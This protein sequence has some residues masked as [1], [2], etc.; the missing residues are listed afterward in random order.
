MTSTDRPDFLGDSLRIHMLG[1]AGA[2]M[3]GL[4]A[5]LMALRHH[6]SGSDKVDTAEVRRLAQL[7]LKF[8]TPHHAEQV[9]GVD[10]VIQS[11]AIKPGNTA[12]D[13]AIRL[14]IPI[15]QRADVLAAIMEHKKGILVCGMHG[16]TTTSAMAAHVLRGGGFKPS[17]YVGAEIPLLKTNAHWEPQSEYFVAEGDESDGTI[18]HYFPTHTLVLNIE[19]E[20]LDYYKNLAAI[21]DVFSRL[22]AQTSEKVF[23]CADDPGAKHVCSIHPRAISY[24][25]HG[26]CDYRLEFL[27]TS[28]IQTHLAIYHRNQPLGKTLLNV[29]GKHNAMN[30]LA[31]TAL[32]TELGIPFDKITA[33]LKSFR[34]AKRRFEIKYRDES[35]MVVDDYGHHPTE[36]QATL[37]TARSLGAQRLVVMFQPH[38]YSRTQALGDKFGI[39]FQAADAVFVTDI[40]A[41]SEIP[42]PG[43][44]GQ[45][46]VDALRNAGHPHAVFHPSVDTIHQAAGRE[47]TNTNLFISLGAGNIHEAGTRLAN[48]LE[49]RKR[50]LSVMGSGSIRLYEPMREHTTLRVGGPAQFWAEPETEEGFATLVRFCSTHNIPL[51]VMGRGSNLLVRDGGI[52]G[53]VAHLVRGEFLHHKIDGFEITAGVGIRLKQLSGIARRA[54]IGGFEWMEGIPGNLG[55]SLRMNAGA[56]GTQTFD[57]VTRIKFCN[58]N[59]KIFSKPPAEFDIRY[60]SVP[61]LVHHYALAATL[62]GYPSST[63]EIDRKLA[64]SE[65]KRHRSQPIASS[66]GCIFKNPEKIPAGQLI[67]ELGLKNFAVGRAR[68]S[69]IHGNFIVNDGCASAEEILTLIDEIQ[70]IARRKRGIELETEVQIVGENP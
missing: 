7:G 42:I 11:S 44:S 60:R 24:G 18:T 14:K 29:P 6:V 12:L 66:A 63:E 34:G 3:S 39:A 45:T 8:E 40:Y 56:M 61:T 53:V 10:L 31:V 69:E 67:E 30:A 65:N 46:I 49:T 2:G 22:I 15:A 17:Y 68:I 43:I 52:L 36:I 26:S 55:G 38:R 27:S 28:D 50:L 64:E 62:L 57:Q 48:D 58:Q 5:L 54:K 21:E 25:S 59:G 41:A 23:Y 70:T 33:A 35:H 13:E 32:A 16:K 20:H 19:P 4:A 37:S 51:M 47:L 9:H 1:V